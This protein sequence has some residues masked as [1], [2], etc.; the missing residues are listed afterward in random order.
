MSRNRVIVEATRATLG[1]RREWP[2]ELVRMLGEPLDAATAKLLEKTL[3]K[4]RTRRASR[5]KPV[6]L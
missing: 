4:V 3:A 1:A 5:R 2:P 6:E